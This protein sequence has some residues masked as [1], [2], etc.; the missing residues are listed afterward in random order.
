MDR[1]EIVSKDVGLVRLAQERY[2]CRATVAMQLAF[3]PLNVR[4][5]S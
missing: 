2:K 4:G 3:G 5:I 1:Q